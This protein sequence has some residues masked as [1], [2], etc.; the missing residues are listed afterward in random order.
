MG[1]V[2]LLLVLTKA[3]PSSARLLVVELVLGRV[4]AAGISV[5]R[6]HSPSFAPAVHRHLP[7]GGF[8]PYLR[9]QIEIVRSV[10]LSRRGAVRNNWRKS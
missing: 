9:I 7:L 2:N 4:A 5:G 6:P 3:R 1:L 8:N 10:R